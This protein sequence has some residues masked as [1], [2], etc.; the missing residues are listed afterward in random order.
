MIFRDLDIKKPTSP[1]RAAP[2]VTRS[3]AVT[4]SAP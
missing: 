2:I 4:P 3:D 1:Q